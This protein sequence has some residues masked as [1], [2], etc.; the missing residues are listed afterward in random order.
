M[1]YSFWS[2]K[3]ALQLDLIK[4]RKL[5]YLIGHALIYFI[6]L[7]FSLKNC[8]PKFLVASNCI[9]KNLEI[10]ISLLNKVI[11]ILG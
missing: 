11:A 5:T 3:I 8:Y 4:L 1:I 6:D 7:G 10:Y 2:Y 9:R